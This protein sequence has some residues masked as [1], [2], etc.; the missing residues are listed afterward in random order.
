MNFAREIAVV[1]TFSQILAPVSRLGGIT[2]GRTR[3]GVE[4]PRPEW[5]EWEDKIGDRA[6]PKAK[7]Q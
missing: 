4:I 5:D 3:E 1:L 2:Y 6:Q 7:G